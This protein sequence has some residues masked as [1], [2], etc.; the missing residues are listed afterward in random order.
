MKNI[1]I[2]S[3]IKVVASCPTEEQD[4]IE[5]FIGV[6]AKVVEHWKQK[7]TVLDKGQVVVCFDNK[8]D[9]ILNDNEYVVVE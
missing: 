5:E 3:I 9:Y 1:K 8:H 7:N 4:G 2:G 6:K